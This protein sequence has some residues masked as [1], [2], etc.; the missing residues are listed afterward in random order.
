MYTINS[1]NII[2]TY[3]GRSCRTRTAHHVDGADGEHPGRDGCRKDAR[4]L[5]TPHVADIQHQDEDESHEE[6]E[7]YEHLEE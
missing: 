3:V 1:R 5:S 4:D 7:R 2:E 6:D